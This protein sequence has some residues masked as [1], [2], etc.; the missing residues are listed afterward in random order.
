MFSPS[1]GKLT[2]SIISRTNVFGIGKTFTGV[3]YPLD[4]KKRHYSIIEFLSGLQ[5]I[6]GELY[7]GCKIVSIEAKNSDDK[8]EVVLSK[9]NKND[10]DDTIEDS[11]NDPS[12]EVKSVFF[13]RSSLASMKLQKNYNT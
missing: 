9:V 2:K 11:D 5:L 4:D 10:I 3:N 13:D 6:V 1:I 8:I 12:W 7:Q